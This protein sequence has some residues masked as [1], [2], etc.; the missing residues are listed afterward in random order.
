MGELLTPADAA[1]IL[2]ISVGQLRGRRAAGKVTAKGRPGRHRRYSA[3]EIRRLARTEA[4]STDETGLSVIA[5]AHRKARVLA[6]H[7]AGDLVLG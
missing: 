7:A 4:D 1:R 2:G 6:A 3:D 5:A